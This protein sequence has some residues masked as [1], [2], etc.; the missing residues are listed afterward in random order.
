M[1]ARPRIGVTSSYGGGRY[2]WWF[3][4]LSLTLMGA[5]PVRLVAP[6]DSDGIDEFDGFIIGGGDDIGA[7]LYRGDLTLD[8]RI[9][10]ARDKME[11]ELL[12]HIRAHD[13]PVLGVCRG[14]QM[15][16]VF[17]GGSLYQDVHAANIDL[18]NLWTPLPRKRV[19]VMTGTRLADVVGSKCL[20][21]NSLH[22]QAI[23]RVGDGLIISAQDEFGIIQAIEDPLHQFHIGVQWHPEFLIYRGSQRR[24]FRAFV[25]A[26][27][28]YAKAREDGSFK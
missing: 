1:N 9:D 26:T 19:R 12:E 20:I 8:V 18:P 25:I 16:N 13:M 11:L 6:F 2:M 10:P 15:L 17:W 27:K 22:H 3:H 4:W 14:A 28:A 5:S 24:L 21:V 23:D 7:E